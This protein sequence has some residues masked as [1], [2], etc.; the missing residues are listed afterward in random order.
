MTYDDLKLTT[1]CQFK[2]PFPTIDPKEVHIVMWWSRPATSDAC[3]R[4]M[5]AV[6]S[7]TVSSPATAVVSVPPTAEVTTS[8]VPKSTTLAPSATNNQLLMACETFEQ[9]LKSPSAVFC[10]WPPVIAG[11]LRQKVIAAFHC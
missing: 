10:F 2:S 1:V 6:R 4:S 9:Q 7:A 5:P 3:S 8:L 11:A